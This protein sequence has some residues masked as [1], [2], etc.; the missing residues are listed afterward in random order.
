MKIYN[1]KLDASRWSTA[2]RKSDKIDEDNFSLFKDVAGNFIFKPDFKDKRF[3]KYVYQ[4][5]KILYDFIEFYY[6]TGPCNQFDYIL[7]NQL[8]G[9]YLSFSLL[10]VKNTVDKAKN[11]EF[12]VEGIDDFNGL[13]V[14][15]FSIF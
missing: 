13:N 5:E 7:S 14:K 10:D 1:R 4:V 2:I 6:N 15:D 11:V 9:Y 12:K 3:K 8:A